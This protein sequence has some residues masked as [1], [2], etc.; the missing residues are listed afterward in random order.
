ME[1][2]L[3]HSK[4]TDALDEFEAAL[5][6]DAVLSKSRKVK[7][8]VNACGALFMTQLNR[9]L[10]KLSTEGLALCQ[11]LDDEGDELAARFL[12]L[13]G[14]GHARLRSASGETLARK[15]WR[16]AKAMFH[17]DNQSVNL[18]GDLFAGVMLMKISDVLEGKRGK[19]VD[20]V[21]IVE[22]FMTVGGQ[23]PK[24]SGG[25]SDDVKKAPESPY[26]SSEK[27][28]PLQAQTRRKTDGSEYTSKLDFAQVSARALDLSVANLKHPT[29]SNVSATVCGG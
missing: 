10:I 7:V 22:E 4:Y 28:P 21:K 12:L 27:P 13:R 3:V 24:D 20:A 16:T 8:L 15:D 6:S 9:R 2:F 29:S 5:K 23:G 1:Q 11:E 26:A 18:G 14:C 25:G 17:N 19:P